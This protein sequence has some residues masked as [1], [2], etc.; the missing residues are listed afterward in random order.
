PRA[1][2][3]PPQGAPRS[4]MLPAHRTRRRSSGSSGPP[5]AGGAKVG[6]PQA[7]QAKDDT[8]LPAPDTR[9]AAADSTPRRGPVFAGPAVPRA[10]YRGGSWPAVA[11]GCAYCATT[12]LDL[13]DCGPDPAL[14]MAWTVNR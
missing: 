7:T 9:S 12:R 8:G 2:T 13:A 5:A 10:N 11:P 4:P 1:P 14:L 6:Q 3:G